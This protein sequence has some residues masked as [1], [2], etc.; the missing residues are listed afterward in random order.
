MLRRQRIA[1]LLIA[2]ALAAFSCAAVAQSSNTAEMVPGQRLFQKYTSVAGS[3]GNARNLVTG[4][5]EGTEIQLSPPPGTGEPGTSFTPPTGKMGFGNVNIA[6]A[7][8]E[9]QLANVEN[10]TIADIQ[11]ALMNGNNGIL[12]LRAQDMGWGQIAHTL[13]FKLGDIM[14]ASAAKDVRAARESRRAQARRLASEPDASRGRSDIARVER[15]ERPD[16]GGRPE[17]VERADGRPERA[18]R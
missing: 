15:F 3:E 18:T 5:R 1:L 13:G 12:T 4:L 6:L 9:A 10:P 16:K 7:L 2:G 8:T 11:N 14:R 17:R